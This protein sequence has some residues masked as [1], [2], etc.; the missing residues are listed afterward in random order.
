MATQTTVMVTCDMCGETK[1]TRTRRI[2]LDG[3]TLEID[4]CGKDSRRL[5]KVAQKFVPFARKISRRPDSRRTASTRQRSA[6]IRAWARS[7]GF[8]MSERGRI[9]AEVERS[10]EAA[11]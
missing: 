8:E 1:D 2:K 9:P 4:L 3:R 11:H 10:Y 5:D 6:G 7:Q